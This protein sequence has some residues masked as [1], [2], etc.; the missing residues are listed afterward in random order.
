MGAVTVDINNMMNVN[1]VGFRALSD[2]L[3]DDGTRVFINQFKDRNHHA[4]NAN[5]TRVTASRMAAILERAATDAEAGRGKGDGDATK[6]KYDRPNIPFEEATEQ[7]RIA[8]MA[9]RAR[10]G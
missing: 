6:E 9:E 3:G 8:D 4:D 1:A 7:I 10:R 5:H 2:A